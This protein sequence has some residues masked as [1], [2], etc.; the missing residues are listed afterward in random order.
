MRAPV[1]AIWIRHACLGVAVV[2]DGRVVVET[3]AQATPAGRGAVVLRAARLGPEPLTTQKR[4]AT[5]GRP[6]AVV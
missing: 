5:V 3:Q 1:E 2:T 4:G 6:A